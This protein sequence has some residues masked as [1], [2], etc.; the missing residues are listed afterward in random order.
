MRLL[1]RC[2]MTRNRTRWIEIG[3]ITELD[4]PPDPKRF[5]EMGGLETS[6]GHPIQSGDWAA[7]S[8]LHLS[9]PWKQDK[10]SESAVRREVQ[11]PEDTQTM[12]R[13]PEEERRRWENSWLVA[14]GD[15]E[16]TVDGLP[17]GTGVGSRT[18]PGQQPNG[19]PGLHQAGLLSW[20]PGLPQVPFSP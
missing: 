18:Q 7:Q 3:N 13:S 9:R 11:T 4:Q 2:N 1:S 19:I 15:A 20:A 6:V 5:Y 8:L 17:W 10:Q 12:S 16:R 14:S